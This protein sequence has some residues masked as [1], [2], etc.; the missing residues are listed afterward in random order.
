MLC[1]F[2]LIVPSGIE[3]HA[4]SLGLRSQVVLIVPSGIETIAGQGPSVFAS[5]Y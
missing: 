4:K 2:V 3:T 5:V 1:P